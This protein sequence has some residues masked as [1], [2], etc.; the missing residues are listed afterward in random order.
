[1][2]KT[3]YAVHPDDYKHYTNE[4]IRN[5]FLIENIFEKDTITHTYSLNDRLIIGGIHPVTR[6]LKLETIDQ[7]KSNFFLERREL[8]IINVG[9]KTSISVDG[10]VFSLD[11]K[12]ALYVG[13]GA[14]DII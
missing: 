6:E 5:E 9:A 4:R 2:S 1:M 3:R 7:L 11:Y 13:R 10:I 12:E 8:G 14:R